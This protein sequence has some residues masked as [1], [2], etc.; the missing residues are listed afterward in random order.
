VSAR[1]VVLY[2]VWVGGLTIA[3]LLTTAE[4]ATAHNCQ[5]FTDCFASADAATESLLGM[6]FL[7]MLSMGLDFVP[8]VGTAKG[9]VEAITGRDLLTGEELSDAER[10]LGI[11]PGGLGKADELLSVGRHADELVDAA[12][13]ADDFVDAGRHADDMADVARHADD[14]P[15]PPRPT[16]GS[17]V[18]T[19]G[20]RRPINSSYA[21]RV[22][23]GPAWTP[24]LASKYPNGVRFT[25]HGFPDFTPYSVA[26][27]EFDDLS[28]VYRTD[29]ARANAAVG[30]RSTPDGYVW[31][32]VED[33]RSMILIP[34]DL[35][36]AIRHTGGSAIIRGGS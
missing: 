4:M 10:L 33:G 13:H 31:H 23:D 32:H 8:Y 24:E 20:G 29:A 21:G 34:R 26:R 9:V 35:H 1:R 2:C 25:D 7:G 5:N 28:G 15:P 3:F 12:R 17:E 18:P 22:Y 16:G 27:T 14:V 36:S 6:T 11:I 30:L 19:I